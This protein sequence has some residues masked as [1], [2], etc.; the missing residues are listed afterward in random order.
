MFDI[1]DVK[2]RKSSCSGNDC[3]DRENIWNGQI[4]VDESGYFE[5]LATVPY[6]GVCVERFIFGCYKNEGIT[7]YKFEPT[8]KGVRTRYDGH[9]F[10]SSFPSDFCV[11]TNDEAVATGNVTLEVLRVPEKE[12]NIMYRIDNWKRVFFDNDTNQL[13][14][15]LSLE[16][17][18]EKDGKNYYVKK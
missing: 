18:R 9:L 4:V 12:L 1:F 10:E 13:Y 15:E 11:C 7:L 16:I 17:M 5:G 14:E 3:I 6:S 2:C 8:N